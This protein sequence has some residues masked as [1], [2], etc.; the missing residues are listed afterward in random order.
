MI[1]DEPTFTMGIEEEY[2]V[3]DRVTRDLVHDLPPDLKKALES[4]A[5]VSPRLMSKNQ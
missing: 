1:P 4:D 2:F 3:V 5:T